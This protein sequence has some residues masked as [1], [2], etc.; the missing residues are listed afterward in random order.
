MSARCEWCGRPVTLSGPP[1]T[2]LVWCSEE[3]QAAWDIANPRPDVD[4]EAVGGATPL[5][6]AELKALLGQGEP[7]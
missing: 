5:Q 6:V 1:W 2:G 3:H 7:S 4:W